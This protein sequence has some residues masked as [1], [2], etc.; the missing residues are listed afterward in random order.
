M[1]D[2]WSVD[3]L[4]DLSIIDLGNDLVPGRR[5]AECLN[6]WF[7]EIGILLTNLN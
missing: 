7:I 6:Q 1:V 2:S 4:M 3:A 5:Q